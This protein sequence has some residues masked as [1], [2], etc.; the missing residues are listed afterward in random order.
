MPLG[1]PSIAYTIAVATPRDTLAAASRPGPDTGVE[2][3]AWGARYP[4]VPMQT[5]RAWSEPQRRDWLASRLAA[6]RAASALLARSGRRPRRIEIVSS[7]AEGR[8]GQ[9][10]VAE[11]VATLTPTRVLRVT[12]SL[13]ISLSH[14][15]GHAIAAAAAH[16]ARIGVDLEREGEIS[17]AHAH[18]FLSARERRTQGARTLT[19]LWAL[20]EAAWKAL[21]C[22]D[23]TP[24]G[25]LELINDDGGAMRAVRLGTMVFPAIAE[26]RH[27]WPGWVAAVLLLQGIAA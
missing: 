9:G 17:P 8:A 6:R 24:F 7:G 10:V 16:P 19:E 1:N 14:T 2:M 11:H 18:Y 21:G 5:E 4:D 25:D 23:S 3:T 27:P 12:L 15:D 26:L 22:G 13:S 20:K